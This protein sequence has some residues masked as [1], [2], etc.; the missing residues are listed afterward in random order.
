MQHCKKV[1]A[2]IMWGPGHTYVRRAGRE[3]G[4][5]GTLRY[6]TG[7]AMALH[8]PEGRHFFIGVNRDQRFET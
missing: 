3:V 5:A 1:G 4:G 7:I 6:H 2:A 8:L